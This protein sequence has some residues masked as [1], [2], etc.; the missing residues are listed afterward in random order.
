MKCLIKFFNLSEFVSAQ[1][2][3]RVLAIASQL[4]AQYTTHVQY[5][6]HCMLCMVRVYMLLEFLNK[7]WQ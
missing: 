2:A 3:L 7:Q 6:T 4:N 1:L 5:D